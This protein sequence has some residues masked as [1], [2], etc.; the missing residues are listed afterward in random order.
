MA[1]VCGSEYAGYCDAIIFGFQATP[2][3]FPQAKYYLPEVLRSIRVI[4]FS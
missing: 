2:P 4:N 1:E 3:E